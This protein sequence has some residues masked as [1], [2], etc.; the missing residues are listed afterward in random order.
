M[1]N[2]SSEADAIQKALEAIKRKLNSDER[3]KIAGDLSEIESAIS[4][5][6]MPPL[7]SNRR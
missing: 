4:N 7:S 5:L 3:A 1:T 6:N 2:I